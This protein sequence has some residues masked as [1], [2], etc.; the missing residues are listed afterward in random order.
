MWLWVLCLLFLLP[1][2][3]LNLFVP[4]QQ[5]QNTTTK[6]HTDITLAKC[7]ALYIYEHIHFAQPILQVGHRGLS[8]L[9]EVTQ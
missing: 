1:Y 3:G 5:W 7:Q 8:N 2:R 9:H 4:K 6:A